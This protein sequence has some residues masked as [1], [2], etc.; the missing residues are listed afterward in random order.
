MKKAL[1]F[2]IT[3]ATLSFCGIRQANAQE[4]FHKGNQTASLLVG[5][6]VYNDGIP[7]ILLS[8]EYCVADNLINGNNGSIGV[9][10]EGGYFAIKYGN[11]T[12]H[13]WVHSGLV[14]GRASFHYQFVNKLDTYA[15]LF[16]GAILTGGSTTSID[17]GDQNIKT[18]KSSDVSAAF[19]WGV[20]VGARYYFTPNFAV[21]AELGYGFSIANL[22]VT[23]RF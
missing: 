19:G 23:F 3:A 15:G 16:L 10:A 20:H 9:G 12:A 2:I 1:L 8:Y 21:N 7:P 5:L 17:L 11:K 22:G 13:S 18:N 14:G 4:I 6:G